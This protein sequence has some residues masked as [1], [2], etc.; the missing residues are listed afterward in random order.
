MN[1]FFCFDFYVKIVECLIDLAKNGDETAAAG[2]CFIED[3]MHACFQYVKTVDDRKTCSFC[4]CG[5]IPPLEYQGK[6]NNYRQMERDLLAYI[7]SQ[8]KVLR[9]A[10]FPNYGIP[11][12]IF[13]GNIEDTKAVKAFTLEVTATVFDSFSE[14]EV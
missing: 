3:T 2:V 8:I 14:T 1:K 10:I 4:E 7:I 9:R 11:G 13:T 6:I 5:Q 12:D